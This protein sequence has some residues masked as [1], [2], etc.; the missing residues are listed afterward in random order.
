MKHILV[1]LVITAMLL[2]ITAC[3]NQTDTTAT[4]P[5]K[6]TPST[7]PSMVPSTEGQLYTELGI[8]LEQ[9]YLRGGIERNPWDIEIYNGRLY[10]GSGD[11]DKNRGPVNLWYYDFDKQTWEIDTFLEDEQAG[12]FC[13]IDGKLYV[14]GFDPRVSWDMGS[15]YRFDGQ[16]W[17][18]LVT[19]PNTLHNFDI[20]KYDGK[21]FAGLGVKEGCSPILV[22]TDEETWEP[23]DLY[24]DGSVVDTTGYTFVRVYDFFTLNGELYAYFS[25][26]ETGKPS[27]HEFYRYDG[28]RFVWHSNMT[29][30]MNFNR[31]NTYTHFCQRVEF[32]GYQYI[33]NANLYRSADMITAKRIMLEGDPEV[34]D[35][36]VIG[37][38]LYALCSEEYTTEEG[39]TAFYISLQ[40]SKDGTTYTEVF[41][42]SYPVRALSFT[43]E[44]GTVFLG[45]G[46]GT[47]ASESYSMYDENGMILAINRVL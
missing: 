7:V 35:L 14:P 10:V 12:R 9:T 5:S 13:I 43:Y 42:F 27:Y 21:L 24:K 15:Y 31:G 47:K 28:E 44:Q 3:G 36:R 30:Y 40:A 29:D 23:V 26:S 17:D 11:Y 46:F 22:T 34:T 16:E 25:L 39:E 41:R 19:L 37:N 33:T 6:T 32:N 1:V 2:T 20:V 8:P 45:M 18:M 4:T 38:T